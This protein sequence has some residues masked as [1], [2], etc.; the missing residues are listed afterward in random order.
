MLHAALAERAAALGD[1][2]HCPPGSPGSTATRRHVAAAGTE[3]RYL[4]AA[5]GLHSTIR[6]ILEREAPPSGA[7]ART[8]RRRA[9]GCAGTTAIRPGQTWWRCTDGPSAEAYV[10]PVSPDIVGVALLF[11]KPPR[12]ASPGATAADRVTRRGGRRLRRPSRR[13]SRRCLTASAALPPASEV[14]GAGPMRQDV[15]A[16]STA[17]CC[18]SATRRATWTR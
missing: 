15:A 18:W 4:V 12:T 11:A 9:T 16:G 14:R 5:D 2:R 13:V 1:L 8:R 10:T 6:R 17:G 3:A 7:A